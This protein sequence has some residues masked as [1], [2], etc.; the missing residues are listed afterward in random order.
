MPRKNIALLAVSLLIFLSAAKLLFGDEALQVAGVITGQKYCLGQPTG[1]SFERVH[2]AAITLMFQ[3]H[4][5]Y[6]NVGPAPLIVPRLANPTLILGSTDANRHSGEVII[7]PKFTREFGNLE[8]R[9]IDLSRPREDFF[10]VLQ[11]GSG[12]QQW[13]TEDLAFRVHDPADDRSRTEWLGKNVFLQLELDHMMIPVAL[14]AELS[15]K[16]R[17]IGTLW[18]GTV[19]TQTLQI[20][21]PLSPA[22]SVCPSQHRID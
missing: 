9:G 17:G 13:M 18:T 7:R 14:A 2:P 6:R 10:K 3:I 5:Y 1:I 19:R 8:E 11:P 22:T 16:W 12:P 20:K 21:I 4:L 15:V